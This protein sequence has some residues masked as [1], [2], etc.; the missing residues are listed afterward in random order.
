MGNQRDE[1][2]AVAIHDDGVIWSRTYGALHDYFANKTELNGKVS[3]EGDQRIDGTLTVRCRLH[4]LDRESGL[5][6]SLYYSYK[7]RSMGFVDGEE[8][9]FRVFDNGDI[10]TPMF[11]WQSHYLSNRLKDKADKDELDGK[12]NAGAICQQ[13]GDIWEFASIDSEHQK[14]IPDLPNPWTLK[15]LRPCERGNRVYMRATQMRNQ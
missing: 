11:G 6:R 3:N 10:W 5:I 8:W 15:G 7:D 14:I 1:P 9:L 4:L 13:A 2:H 12:A